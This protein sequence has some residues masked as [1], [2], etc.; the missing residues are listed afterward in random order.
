M[1]E[2][3][4]THQHLWDLSRHGYGWCAGIPLL[5]RSYTMPDYLVAAAGLGVTAT[6]HVEA[7][8]DEADMT[9]E[10]RWL[11]SMVRDE[12]NPMRGLV[13]KALPERDEF[14]AYL[15]Q[16][17]GETA[18]KGVRR[19]FHT[20]PDD[21]ALDKRVQR[22]IATLSRRGLSFDLCALPRQLPAVKALVRACPDVTFVLDHCGIPDIKGQ[23]L[24]PW[25]TDIADLAQCPNIAAC[26]V[27]GLVAYAEAAGDFVQQLQPYVDHVVQQF[28]PA[29]VMFGSDWPVCLL[30][31]PL[32]KWVET[33]KTLTC[34][35]SESDRQL[36][37]GGNARRVYRLG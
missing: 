19:V 31:A 25:R 13:V 29:R 21:F 30:A 7:D 14:E 15:D 16:F 20:Q 34:D 24:D 3:V 10:T 18:I 36:L 4:D 6:V 5:H 33:L 32:A 27:S 11:L 8:V 22:N 9:S 17:A 37:F 23:Q 26:K 35:L 12:S 1:L 2:I 28:G